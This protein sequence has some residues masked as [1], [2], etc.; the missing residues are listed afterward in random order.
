MFEK[1]INTSELQS[2]IVERDKY[3][4]EVKELAKTLKKMQEDKTSVSTVLKER[5]N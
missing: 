2:T 5:M 1:D 4:G 3:R